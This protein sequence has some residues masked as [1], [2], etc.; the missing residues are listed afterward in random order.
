MNIL[1]KFSFLSI[2]ILLASCSSYN[3]EDVINYVF[4][5]DD[6]ILKLAQ[7]SLGKVKKPLEP[8]FTTPFDSFAIT[9]KEQKDTIII[10]AQIVPNRSTETLNE[11][12]INRPQSLNGNTKDELAVWNL[13]ANYVRA[14]FKS[15]NGDTLNYATETDY[16]SITIDD[17][18]GEIVLYYDN[19]RQI[20]DLRQDIVLEAQSAFELT[21]GSGEVVVPENEIW[22]LEG[23]T[24][25]RGKFQGEINQNCACPM[26]SGVGG[27]LYTHYLYPNIKILGDCFHAK[28]GRTTAT[29]D[30]VFGLDWEDPAIISQIK[31]A[32]HVPLNN[33]IYF[34]VPSIEYGGHIGVQQKWTGRKYRVR[35]IENWKNY[36]EAVNFHFMNDFGVVADLEDYL[37][38]FWVDQNEIKYMGDDFFDPDGEI[39]D[40]RK[41]YI[42]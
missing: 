37:G 16:L 30:P 23:F 17:R 36:L 11:L 2:L 31:L 24:M 7:A 1:K 28:H 12:Q 40:Y 38:N 34:C 18:E 10:T 22:M 25:I 6:S 20:A 33:S 13:L 42:H 3:E 9:P 29:Y 27:K 8:P 32:R 35:E 15:L 19:D 41:K 39:S 14:N 26:A 21:E 5:G 4:E